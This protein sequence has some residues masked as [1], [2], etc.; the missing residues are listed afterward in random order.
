MNTSDVLKHITMATKGTP[1]NYPQVK[2]VQKPKGIAEEMPRIDDA[3]M[4]VD[5]NVIYTGNTHLHSQSMAENRFGKFADK[6]A[7]NDP[8]RLQQYTTTMPKTEQPKDPGKYYRDSGSTFYEPRYSNDLNISMPVPKKLGYNILPIGMKKPS[9]GM[10]STRKSK[11]RSTRTVGGSLERNPE[12][13]N[14]QEIVSPSSESKTSKLTVAESE[15]LKGPVAI[16]TSEGGTRVTAESRKEGL[17]DPYKGVG[18]IGPRSVVKGRI[19]GGAIAREIY[20]TKRNA[21]IQKLIDKGK[22]KPEDLDKPLTKEEEDMVLAHL[23][24]IDEKN[25]K[26]VFYGIR[27][28]K[29]RFGP[30]HRLDCP[31]RSIIDPLIP[32]VGSG[33]TPVKLKKFREEIYNLGSTMDTFLKNYRGVGMKTKGSGLTKAK[34]DARVKQ[35]H[36]DIAKTLKDEYKIE[37][38]ASPMWLTIDKSK[39][40][41]QI[42]EHFKDLD[43]ILSQL[44]TELAAKFK[45]N[46]GIKLSRGNV[47]LPFPS[48]V[49]HDRGHMQSALSTA[50]KV[51]IDKLKSI[52]HHMKALRTV[53]PNTLDILEEYM[54]KI[55]AARTEEVV[56]DALG[57]ATSYNIDLAVDFLN[58]LRDGVIVADRVPPTSVIYRLA[59]AILRAEGRHADASSF[60]SLIRDAEQRATRF[61]PEGIRE[62][63]LPI[64][65]RPEST[66]TTTTTTTTAT[67]QAEEKG[68]EPVEMALIDI[69]GPEVTL[70]PEALKVMEEKKAKI[71]AE[72]RERLKEL[73]ITTE[74]MQREYVPPPH[75]ATHA[76]ANLAK[77]D[78]GVPIP[79]TTILPEL[80]EFPAV[81]RLPARKRREINRIIRGVNTGKITMATG[82]TAVLAAIAYSGLNNLG[83]SGVASIFDWFLS[84]VGRLVKPADEPSPEEAVKR[85]QDQLTK[86]VELGLEEDVEPNVPEDY[87]DVQPP[88]EDRPPL[89]SREPQEQMEEEDGEPN[90]PEDYEDVQS[91]EEDRPP[92][93]SREPEEDRPP[94]SSLEPQEQMGEEGSDQPDRSREPDLPQSPGLSS[95]FNMLRSI[96]GKAGMAGALKYLFDLM[97]HPATRR[98]AKQLLWYICNNPEAVAD[99]FGV[100]LADVKALCGIVDEIE[101]MI[102]SQAP[103]KADVETIPQRREEYK[104]DKADLVK[105]EAVREARFK[106]LP[107]YEARVYSMQSIPTFISATDPRHPVNLRK[108]VIKV[109]G[110]EFKKAPMKSPK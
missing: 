45:L 96:M 42:N 105:R 71:H 80:D 9:L 18:K 23:P 91:P 95:M 19:Y 12:S 86:V 28:I 49:R 17:I 59:Q 30:I 24:N 90:V 62:E 47:H 72:L 8:A 2:R 100:P 73:P 31:I 99:L 21:A 107:E 109:L 79:S 75:I 25:I 69:E 43:D 85:V 84:K 55:P 16:M 29:R 63:L 4:S 89:S 87:E 48:N 26:D 78:E 103:V 74:L 54:K 83:L 1:A 61:H 39:W 38:P 3:M 64:P 41:R 66:T 108:P 53:K 56:K 7:V 5:G 40:E 14:V 82:I 57:S 81:G 68:K 51:F 37:A 88:E 65:T 44:A 94:P 58:G 93:S 20:R 50:Y 60:A 32:I 6:K 52:E 10:S 13:A 92:P 27:G 11:V 67:E 110:G 104:K 102:P 106:A 34:V 33:L 22:A 15:R 101:D 97:M 36:E 77:G 76:T 46:M 35:Y 70:S 98:Y